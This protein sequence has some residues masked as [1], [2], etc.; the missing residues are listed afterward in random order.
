LIFNIYHQDCVL[1]HR[2][3]QRQNIVEKA[4]A[5]QNLV[6]PNDSDGKESVH[7]AVD[8]GLIPGSG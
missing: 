3:K 6:F 4:S 8:P 2:K 1:D 5:P 7:N